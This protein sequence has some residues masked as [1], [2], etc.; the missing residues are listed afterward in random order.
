AGTP[1]HST[2]T[3]AGSGC[4][5]EARCCA[6]TRSIWWPVLARPSTVAA[7]SCVTP[8]GASCASRAEQDEARDSGAQR[9]LFHQQNSP[10]RL[11]APGGERRAT[12]R[13]ADRL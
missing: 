10:Q 12:N 3:G 4:A 8:D 9:N 13:A 7:P 11:T 5:R 6:R 2:S 1:V